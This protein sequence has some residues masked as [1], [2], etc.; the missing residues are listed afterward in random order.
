MLARSMSMFKLRINTAPAA[1]SGL[2]NNRRPLDTN[3]VDRH[4]SH[5]RLPQY[6]ETPVTP[7]FTDV[8]VLSSDRSF[9]IKS[10]VMVTLILQ[11]QAIEFI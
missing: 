5:T 9:L 1:N 2:S 6:D 4:Y 11:P 7:E 10:S 3:S 8:F